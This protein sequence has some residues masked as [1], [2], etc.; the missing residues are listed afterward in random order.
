MTGR[1]Y[2]L[3]ETGTLQS[4]TERPYASEKLLQK[5]LGDYPDLLAGDQIN[6]TT[7]RR[8]LLISREMGIPL[9]Q[10]SGD[11]MSLDHLF[12]D[13][14]AIPTL[15]EVKRSSDTRIRRQVVGQ[16]L[17]YAAH[18][19][20]YWSV[21]TIRARLEASCESTGADPIDLVVQLVEAELGDEGA[22]ETF[23]RQVKTNLQAGRIRLIFVAD[24]IPPELRR[25][26]EFLNRFMDPVEVLAVEVKQYVGQ[27]LKT[28]V[29]RVI[30]QTAEAQSKKLGGAAPGRQWDEPSFFQE[31]GERHGA[32]AVAVATRI[33]EWARARADRLWW[34]RGSK[35]GS[36]VPVLN[37]KQRDHQLFAVWTYGMVELYFYWYQFKPPFKS[38]EL[39]REL[40]GRLNAIEGIALP[41][42]A[43]N[44]RPSIGMSA[45]KD[46]TALNEFLEVFD[47]V[48]Q[49][50]V[51]T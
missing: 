13:Q 22:V 50:I 37:H 43:I 19:V 27:D 2:L 11:Q 28:L 20:A 36:Y 14:D 49:E 23:W 10:D 7:P 38:E 33:L 45:L 5:L 31:L 15:I 32:E 44:R 51:A 42:E 12:L 46:E 39:R 35:S 4:L 17:D 48:A 24:D 16:M 3:Q 9:E 8:W 40:L 29:P 34:G 41:D 1:I 47:W 25:V 18:A 21:Q 26:V 6:E 30:G